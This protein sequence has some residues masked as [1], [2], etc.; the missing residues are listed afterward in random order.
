MIDSSMAQL[1][2]GR[3]RDTKDGA[4]IVDGFGKPRNIKKWLRDDPVIPQQKNAPGQTLAKWIFSASSGWNLWFFCGCS[5]EFFYSEPLL[6]KQPRCWNLHL[7]RIARFTVRKPTT[8]VGFRIT[9][10]CFKMSAGMSGFGVFVFSTD[11][12][13]HTIH[14]TGIFTYICLIFM[15]NVGK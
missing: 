6:I 10:W 3:H 14:G 5:H 4:T 9:K 13:T 1:G 7:P 8:A 2:P 11:E 12:I 15:G